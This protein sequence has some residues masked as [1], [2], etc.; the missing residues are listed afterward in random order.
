MNVPLIPQDKANHYLYGT[1]A[2]IMSIIFT[3]IGVTGFCC[4]MHFLDPSFKSTPLSFWPLLIASPMIGAGIVGFRKEYKDKQGG[5]TYEQ[6]D[7]Y[8]TL[9]GG[10]PV[11]IGASVALLAGII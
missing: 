1:I 9:A 11:S 6:A 4:L 7:F 2:G 5:G 10:V 3:F 8:F